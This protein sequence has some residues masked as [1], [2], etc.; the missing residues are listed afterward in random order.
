MVSQGASLNYMC[1][2]SGS[3]YI[4]IMMKANYDFR[5]LRAWLYLDKDK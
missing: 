5:N 4:L 3:H 2:L 1:N